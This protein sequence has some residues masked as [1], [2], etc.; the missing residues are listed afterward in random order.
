MARYNEQEVA[1]INIIRNG[2]TI[3]G[4]INSGGDIRIDGTLKGTLVCEGKLVIGDSGKIEG[5]VF[6][7]NADISGKMNGAL[8]VKELLQLKNTAKVEGEI[9]IGKL[10]IEPGAIFTGT[11]KM[12]K[13]E[14]LKQLEKNKVLKT[15]AIAKETA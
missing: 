9:A 5:E 1:A 7:K 4:T 12:G 6:C 13:A 15:P 8:S 10:A 14:N 3:E 11:C 2:T